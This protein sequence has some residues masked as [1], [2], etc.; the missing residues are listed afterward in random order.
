MVYSCKIETVFQ[1]YSYKL[2]CQVV[3][4]FTCFNW[5]NNIQYLVSHLPSCRRSKETATIVAV[6]AFMSILGFFY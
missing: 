4:S 2:T 3:H 5:S 1:F 6:S